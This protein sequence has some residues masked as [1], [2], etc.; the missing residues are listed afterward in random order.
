MNWGTKIA[1]FYTTFVVVILSAVVKSTFHRW[2]L[3]T[4]D[5]YGEE[6]KYQTQIDKMNNTKALGQQPT[7]QVEGQTIKV[8]FPEQLLTSNIIGK[9]N[10]YKPSDKA[11][12]FE[13]AI[14]L[15]KQGKQ[16]ITPTITQKGKY[17]AQLNWTVNGIDY[18]KE[19][20]LFLP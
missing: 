18:Y 20:F 1:I 17:T 5:Y 8:A 2:D 12:D 4:E 6:I 7:M 14:S 15:D 16:Y 9:I 11:L 3:V 10:F 19:F 13:A